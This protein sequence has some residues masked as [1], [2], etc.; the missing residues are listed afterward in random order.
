VI[1]LS[2]PDAAHIY[3]IPL[4]TLYRWL[5]EGRI[6]RHG[7]RRPYHV[8]ANEVEQLVALPRREC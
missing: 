8:D 7:E 1:L 5:S 6:V 3:G 2:L 4:G